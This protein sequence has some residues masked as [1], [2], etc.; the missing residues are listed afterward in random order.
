LEQWQT[1]SEG[2]KARKLSSIVPV[3]GVPFLSQT[4][5]EKHMRITRFEV[6]DS[7]CVI[8]LDM[9]N[10]SLDIPQADSFQIREQWLIYSD[11]S[12]TQK[13]ILR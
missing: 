5:H 3:K 1:D 12:S 9:I 13:C 6:G 8:Q 11:H 4:R 10:R 2:V 7:P